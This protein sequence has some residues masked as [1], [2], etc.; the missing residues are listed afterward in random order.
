MLGFFR[1]FSKSPIGIGIFALIL[2]AFVVTLYEGKSGFGLPGVSSSAVA[3]V[4]GKDIDEGELAR[5]VQNQLEGERRRNPEMDMSQFVAGGGVEKTVDL[6]ITGRAL[7]I[8]AAQQGMVASK[9]LVDGAISSIPAFYGP[10]GRFDQTTFA[11]VLAQRKL[12]EK[13]VRDDFAREALT[14]MLA[15][16]AA[17]AAR[18]PEKLILPYASLLLESRSGQVAV[19]PSKAFEPK[20]APT[21]T[22]LQTFYQRNI[23]RYTLP[24]RR[25]VRYARFDKSRVTA[26]SVATD[27]E[28]Q[29]AYA[30]DAS[31]AARDKRAFTQIIVPTQA[32]A[33]DLLN[34]V[35]GGMSIADA[36]KSVQ[37]EPLTVAS[38]DKTAFA[39]LT[40]AR[41]ADSAFAAAKGDFAAVERSGLG[42][43]VVR[44]DAVQ[45]IAATPLSA[46]RAKLAAE[47]TEQKE[48]RAIADL[49]VQMEDDAGN[50]V[51]FDELVK[52]YALTVETTPALTGGGTS[53]D[54]P[55]YRAAP[56]VAA[57]LTDAF[58]AEP[59]D[60]PAVATLAGDAG[61]VLW[62]LDRK[63]PA[64]PK[65]LAEVRAMV[66]ADVQ[67]D[68]GSKAAKI[69]A[70]KIVAAV[71]AGTPLG[72]ALQSVGVALPPAQP[73]GARRLELA[74]A[75]GK[76][77]PPLAMMFAMPEKRARTLQVEGKQG[78]YVVYVD[79][80]VAGDARTA[81]GLIQATQQQL[82]GAIGDEYVEQFAKAVRAEVGATKSDAGLAKLK[83]SLTGS[84]AR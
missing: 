56:E 23:A 84:G 73:A 76:A 62:K 50:N 16:P 47:I 71:N 2:I 75:Q 31:Y 38:T 13:V 69:A 58:R 79:K 55:G 1:R 63:V 53:F 59:D 54:V 39:Q 82:S 40:G 10:T 46:V 30:A 15:I 42:F 70:D 65:P 8:F 78:W 80:I 19:V 28:I 44:V 74:Q 41:V 4:G 61:Y 9:K 25:V 48:K 35:R 29:S 3:T 51:T 81:P 6:T 83:A 43:H 34:K 64:A 14:K 33:N 45:G 52:K 27:A 12:S 7:E 66:V 26:K 37:R 20:T 49:I 60:D 17:G 57:F 21:D 18:V 68:K 77:P 72:T 36:A 5:R 24:E 32:Q 22:E 11:Q 67:V